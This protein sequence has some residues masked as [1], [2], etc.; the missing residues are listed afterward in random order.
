MELVLT[1]VGSY[2][3]IGDAPELQRHRRAYAQWERKEISEEAFRK[4]EDEVTAEVIRE[5][6]EAGVELVTDGQVRWYDPYSHLARGLEGVEINGLLRLFDTN[7]YFRQPVVKGPIRR[8]G[9]I[10]RREYEFARSVSS[11]PVK[12]VLTGP[13]TL[14]RGSVLE[15]GY[16]AF[17]ALAMAYAE[18]LAEEVRDLAGAGASLIQVD[19]PAIVRYPEDVGLLQEALT[20]VARARG[21]ARLILHVSFGDVAP[22]YRD[23]QALPADVLSLD[24]SYSPKLPRLVA[25]AGSSKPLGLGLIDGRNTRL[26]T[27]E[28]VFPI[29]D[30]VLP[31]L[32]GGAAYLSPTCGLEFLPRDRARAKLE[33]MRRLRDAY[34]GGHV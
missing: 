3:R 26:E 8:K 13:Y 9:P 23:L 32:P 30:R 24:F 2:P 28:M 4:V 18:V 27:P 6:I 15:G 17:P 1:S 25:E 14:A 10:L 7:F 29:L 31:K 16:R 21:P 20:S 19:E 33:T 5:Q 22:L 11:Q 12:P 34:L